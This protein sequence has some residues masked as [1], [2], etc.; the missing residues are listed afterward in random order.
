MALGFGLVK[1]L[2]LKVYNGLVKVNKISIK[3]TGVGDKL[4]DGAKVVTKITGATSGA[5]G[6]AKGSVDVA[7]AIACKDGIC[8]FVSAVG[9]AA[10][11]LQIMASFVPGPNVTAV[12]TT[13]VSIGCKVFVWC[14]KRSKLPWGSC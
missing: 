13:P 8:A 4:S 1:K 3:V 9:C 7:E 2:S 11:S 14:C 5:A 10:D 12:I 6:L